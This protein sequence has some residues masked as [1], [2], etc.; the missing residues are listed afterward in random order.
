M[1]QPRGLA[2]ESLDRLLLDVH[3]RLAGMQGLDAQ[4]GELMRI[5]T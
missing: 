3:A 1:T 4:L 5:V 2:P